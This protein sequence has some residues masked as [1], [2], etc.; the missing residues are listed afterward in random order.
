MAPTVGSMPGSSDQTVVGAAM[1]RISRR[2]RH[3][4][5]ASRVY[6]A[7]RY[8]RRGAVRKKGVVGGARSLVVSEA[9]SVGG[10]KVVAR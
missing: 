2:G 5:L 8:G 10:R 1:L 6:E 4:R 7:L 3:V 9:R